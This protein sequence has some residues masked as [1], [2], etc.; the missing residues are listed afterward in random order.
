MGPWA[1]VVGLT[2]GLEI[3]HSETL[4]IGLAWGAGLGIHGK[5]TLAVSSI[6]VYLLPLHLHSLLTQ[7]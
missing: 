1:A 6:L 4:G 5:G 2:L 3:F 7:Q